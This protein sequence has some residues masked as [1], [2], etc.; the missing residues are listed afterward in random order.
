MIEPNFDLLLWVIFI[1]CGFTG[2]CNIIFGIVE[3]RRKV[4]DRLRDIVTG[5]LILFLMFQIYLLQFSL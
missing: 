4:L 2:I 3:R 1:F 5:L